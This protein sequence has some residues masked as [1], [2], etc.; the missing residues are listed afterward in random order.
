M[1]VLEYLKTLL[2]SWLIWPGLMFVVA[3]IGESRIL[4]VWG[5][6]SRAFMPGNMALTTIV[7]NCY[8]FWHSEYSPGAESILYKYT[9][10]PV[11][12]VVIA[13]ASVFIGHFLHKSDC[14]NYPKRAANSPT[15]WVHDVTGY[16][17]LMFLIIWLAPATIF[18]GLSIYAIVNLF[19][20]AFYMLTV[21]YDTVVGIN[22]EILYTRHPYDWKPIWKTRKLIQYDWHFPCK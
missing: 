6:Q 12:I 3:L 13:L 16:F 19:L 15:K 4:P 22:N 11:T 8:Y 14:K 2:L 17:G 5:K 9:F 20:G 21:A 1:A 18:S 7:L 10:H